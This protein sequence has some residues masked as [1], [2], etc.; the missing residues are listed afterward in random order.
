MQGMQPVTWLLS[1]YCRLFH[2]RVLWPVCGRYR[3]ATC[4]RVWECEAVITQIERQQERIAE[5]EQVVKALRETL[6]DIA[7]ASPHSGRRIEKLFKLDHVG[8]SAE[9]GELLPCPFCG[10]HAAMHEEAFMLGSDT[11]YRVECEG[12]CHAMTY[13]WHSA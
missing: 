8:V 6:E 4:L 7:T 11:G 1:A 5:L 13:W 12:A 10:C 9:S 3:C 2:R